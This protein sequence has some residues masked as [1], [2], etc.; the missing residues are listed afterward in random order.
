MTY[1]EL[2]SFSREGLIAAPCECVSCS[3]CDGSGNLWLDMAGRF[4]SRHRTDDMSEM[5]PCD[6]CRGSGIVET[7]D[8]CH[9][10]EEMDAEE[11]GTER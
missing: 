11:L 10:L 7:C 4:L 1:Q 9:L 5:E 6:N 2:C 3:C 8:R